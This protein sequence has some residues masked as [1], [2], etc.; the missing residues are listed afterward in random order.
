[1]HVQRDGYT[2]LNHI[3]HTRIRDHQT[4]KID[5]KP[6]IISIR[7]TR[8]SQKRGYSWQ[9][10][11]PAPA[12]SFQAHPSSLAPKRSLETRTPARGNHAPRIGGKKKSKSTGDPELRRQPI[13]TAK[14]GVS[15][16]ISMVWGTEH[17]RA[18]SKHHN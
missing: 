11:F 18:A 4:A 15:L 3:H 9:H 6:P 12:S 8:D 14:I 5:Y 16:M 2:V 1:M 17:N 7:E 13:I 10:P